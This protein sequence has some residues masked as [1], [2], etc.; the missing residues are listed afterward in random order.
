[1]NIILARIIKS[2]S[3]GGAPQLVEGQKPEIGAIVSK[4]DVRKVKSMTKQGGR[5]ILAEGGTNEDY[6]LRTYSSS[7]TI[8]DIAKYAQISPA[9]P[10]DE[11]LNSVVFKK[12]EH[13]NYDSGVSFDGTY[14]TTGKNGKNKSQ[15]YK[16]K[17]NTLTYHDTNASSEATVCVKMTNTE[18]KNDEKSLAINFSVAAYEYNKCEEVEDGYKILDD[19]VLI[20][21]GDSISGVSFK[22]YDTEQVGHTSQEDDTM[23]FSKSRR[24][25]DKKDF[26]KVFYSYKRAFNSRAIKTKNTAYKRAI[27]RF[28]I[29]DEEQ[30]IQ[31]AKKMG[32]A[33]DSATAAMAQNAYNK[34]FDVNSNDFQQLCDVIKAIQRNNTQVNENENGERGTKSASTVDMCLWLTGKLGSINGEQVT[35]IALLE[36]ISQYAK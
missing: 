25:K 4:S 34:K 19:T 12:I 14:Y 20:L 24:D 32:S 17:P 7:A 22:P 35:A 8:T 9:E 27:E 30:F 2:E 29:T 10:W 13:K 3:H 6:I 33:L 15:K 31:E 26:E 23:Y 16:I 18:D 28:N 36:K 11:F 5:Y 21:D 1:M